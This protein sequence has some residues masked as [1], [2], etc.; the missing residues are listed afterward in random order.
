VTADE[1][2]RIMPHVVADIP[3]AVY[4]DER[5]RGL[6]AWVNFILSLAANVL[7]VSASRS[8]HLEPL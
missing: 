4:L 6:E 5:R 7:A 2:F 8:L 1:R 3:G